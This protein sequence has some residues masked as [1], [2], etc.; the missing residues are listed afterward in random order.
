[1]TT[2]TVLLLALAAAAAAAPYGGTTQRCSTECPLAAAKLSFTPGKTYSYTY[3]G[4]SNV[5]LKG[6]DGG[7][8]ETQWEKQVLLTVLGPCDVAISFKGSKVDGKTGLPGSDKLERYPLVVAMTD[9]RVQRV[10]SH[11]DDD[12]W[13]INMKKGVVSALQISLPSLSISNSGLNFT[14][15]DVLGTCPTYYEVQAEGAKVLVKKEKNHR[16]C[17]EH[18]PTPDEINLPHLMGPLPIQESR[19][20]CRQEIDS[21]IISSVV[22]E[23]KKVIRPSYGIYK[24]HL[25]H[26]SGRAGAQEPRYDY[27]TAKKDPSLVPELEQTLRYLCEITTDGVEA[28]AAAQLSKAVHLMRLIP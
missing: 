20:S 9:G 13:A 26:W 21:G 24:Y 19:S 23:D 1:M 12:T 3:T 10:C 17:Q 4:K 5:Q 2:H 8:V 6:V 27:E 16:L 22:C 11:P 7:I 18:Y 28:H 25:P 15:T 14:E